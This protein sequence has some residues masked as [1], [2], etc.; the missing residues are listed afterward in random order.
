MTSP[1]WGREYR[2]A[3]FTVYRAS[4]LT[5]KYPHN[6]RT[7]N[8]TVAGNCG[9]QVSSPNT[10]DSSFIN[11]FFFFFLLNQCFRISPESSGYNIF[12][13]Y[14]K[15]SISFMTMWVQIKLSFFVA[16]PDPDPRVRSGSWI[17]KRGN[18]KFMVGEKS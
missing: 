7:I 14:N 17:V 10:D 8:N 12:P 1:G 9:G 18:L 5:G 2:K 13:I 15:I 3:F 16:N 11:L 4:L 6:T